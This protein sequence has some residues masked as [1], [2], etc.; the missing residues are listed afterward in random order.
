MSIAT[1]LT[2]TVLRLLGLLPLFVL[3]A[4][5][6]GL[7]G[8][9]R[10][11]PTRER[12]VAA[13]NLELCLPD[14][15]AAER[16]ALWRASLATAGEALLEL[17]WLWTRP[18]PAVLG[19]IR[20]IDGREHFDA[21]LAEG[22]GVILA[23]PHLGAW[24][25]LN[26]WLAR[27]CRMAVLY[28]P[29]RQPWVEAVL[30][31]GR[32]RAGALP[33]PADA[34]GVRQLLRHL[35]E[36]GVVGILPDQQPKRGEGEFAPFFGL[37]AFTMTLLPRLAAR[38]AVPVVFAWAERLPRGAGYALVFRPAVPPVADVAAL[39]ANVEAC[40]RALPAQYQWTYK[41][42]SMRPEGEPKLYP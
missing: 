42:F 35:R 28:R 32:S 30:N 25:L 5:G 41:R 16:R 37:Q 38:E 26:L 4:L 31:R 12:K 1:T 14:A 22:R 24:E 15:S 9:W 11:L 29:P 20:S 21:A 18:L 34:K 3:H 6:R 27:H 40:A 36:G 10:L 39:N 19:V 33:V 2:W 8:L 13:R 23:A 17:P 7:G